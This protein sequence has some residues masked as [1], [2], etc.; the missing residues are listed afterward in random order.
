[1]YCH[2]TKLNL[3]RAIWKNDLKMKNRKF[4]T[5][6]KMGEGELQAISQLKTL[7]QS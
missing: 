6:L 5:K 7:T 4:I 1:M 3:I 2:Q